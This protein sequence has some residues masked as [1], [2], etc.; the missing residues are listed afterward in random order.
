MA[1][2]PMSAVATTYNPDSGSATQITGKALDGNHSGVNVD[3]GMT[4]TCRGELVDAVTESSLLFLG[5]IKQTLKLLS[6]CKL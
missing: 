6:V 3:C 2:S 1:V 5:L 4:P